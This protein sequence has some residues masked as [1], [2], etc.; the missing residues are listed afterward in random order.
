MGNVVIKFKP[1][2]MSGYE[3]QESVEFQSAMFAIE[4]GLLVVIANEGG[5]VTAHPL[6]DVLS[7]GVI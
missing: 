2:A 4:D 7:Y 3:M 1:E 6:T 5:I